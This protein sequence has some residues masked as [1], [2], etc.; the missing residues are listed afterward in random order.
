M[1]RAVLLTDIRLEGANPTH[2]KTFGRQVAKSIKSGKPGRAWGKIDSVERGVDGT[3]TM[4]MSIP[5][6][7][8]DPSTRLF[9]Q[10]NG[11][12]A[13]LAEDLISKMYKMARTNRYNVS[14]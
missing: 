1:T 2:T 9:I 4:K 14:R 11:V 7:S 12:P 5:L 6:G 10:K 8:L 3:I 13:Y